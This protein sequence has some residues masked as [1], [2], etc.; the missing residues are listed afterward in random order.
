MNF[1]RSN[2]IAPCGVMAAWSCKTLKSFK[3]IFAFRK[4]H[5]LPYNFQ[6]S[7]SK[8]FIATL[9]DV[10]CLNFAKF[11]RRENG[12]IV[13]SVPYQKTTKFRLDFQL[14]LLRGSRPKSVRD[15]PRQCTQSAPSKSVH[16][17]RRSYS[18]TRE[19]LQK[20]NREYIYLPSRADDNLSHSTQTK[21]I[22][23]N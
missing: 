14:S 11:C 10:L 6:N 8:V 12:E 13:R 18:R 23:K 19:C 1:R 22:R 5:P 20:R 4:K 17:N 16:F 3:E 2:H 21:K 15:S 7:V 9:I